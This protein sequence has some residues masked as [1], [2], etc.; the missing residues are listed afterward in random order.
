[1][2]AQYIYNLAY[3]DLLECQLFIKIQNYPH[4]RKDQNKNIT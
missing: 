2:Y 4:E 1:M 3:W